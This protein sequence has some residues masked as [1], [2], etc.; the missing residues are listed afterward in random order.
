MKPTKLRKIL[1]NR[2]GKRF[3]YYEVEWENGEITHHATLED[4]PFEVW[5]ILKEKYIRKLEKALTRDI[6]EEL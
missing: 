3:I 6:E 5:C 4:L 1:Y 2:N